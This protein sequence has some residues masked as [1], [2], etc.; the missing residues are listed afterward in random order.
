[1][2]TRMSRAAALLFV[3]YSACGPQQTWIGKISDSTC[4][5]RHPEDEHAVPQTDKECT[6]ACIRSGATYTFVSMDGRVY[7]IANKGEQSLAAHSGDIV[8]L[9]GT[10]EGGILTV[11]RIEMP[12]R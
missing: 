2:R 12:T 1:M 5:A 10:A 6:L 11:S 7:E 8:R 9:T 3:M 4:G